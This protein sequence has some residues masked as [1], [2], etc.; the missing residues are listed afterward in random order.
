[1]D[2]LITDDSGFMRHI[3]REILEGE[4]TVVGEAENGAE[5]VEL[6]EE[7]Q[8]DVVFMDIIMPVKGG[9]EAADEITD[10]DPEATVVMCTSVEQVRQMKESIAAGANGYI[11]KP[12]QEEQVLEKIK[13]VGPE[14]GHDN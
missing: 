5:A 7:T 14:Q 9:I 11:T 4:H 8:P 1:M 3:L 13:R 6:Y 2:I 10:I 12:F